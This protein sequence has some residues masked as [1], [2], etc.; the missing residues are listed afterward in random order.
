MKTDFYLTVDSQTYHEY[1]SIPSYLYYMEY[2]SACSAMTIADRK[3]DQEFR[4]E[5]K[6][7]QGITFVE[8]LERVPMG[9]LQGRIAYC[10]VY[11]DTLENMSRFQLEYL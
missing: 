6:R 1:S 11:F 7:M 10:T 9:K 4:Y 3:A 8:L 5:A 2:S